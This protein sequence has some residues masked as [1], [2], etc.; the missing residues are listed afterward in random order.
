MVSSNHRDVCG[1]KCVGKGHHVEGHFIDYV[2]I[3]DNQAF[4]VGVKTP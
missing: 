2:G 1:R 3:Y 4:G